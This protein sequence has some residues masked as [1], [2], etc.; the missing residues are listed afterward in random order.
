[1]AFRI[2]TVRGELVR[3]NGTQTVRWDTSRAEWVVYCRERRR[4]FRGFLSVGNAQDFCDGKTR[5]A[6]LV[7]C[8]ATK[9]DRSAP[10]ADLYTS[11]LF[12]VAR[13]YAEASGHPWF[14]LSARH[15][16]VEPTTIL[17]PYDTKLSDLK[18]DERSAWANRVTYALYLRGFG[19]WGV[20]EIHA[21]DAYARPLRDALAPIALD[22]I[23]PLDGLGIGQRL[24][25]YAARRTS[26]SASTDTGCFGVNPIHTGAI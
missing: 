13:C 23:E 20:F 21:G 25:W 1:M 6:I 2:R 24:H 17:E 22:I 3:D 16:L 5:R 7:S 14:I 11:P 4:H 19:G 9:L 15:G 26:P 8:A 18:P 10:A 12:R